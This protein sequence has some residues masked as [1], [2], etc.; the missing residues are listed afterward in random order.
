[1]LTKDNYRI[2]L[3]GENK[4][5]IVDKNSPHIA[6]YGTY[7]GS[8]QNVATSRETQL[9]LLE[10]FKSL[11]NL[12]NTCYMNVVLQCLLHTPLF[13]NYLVSGLY[14]RDLNSKEA[15]VTSLAQLAIVYRKKNDVTSELRNFKTRL[16]KVLPEFLPAM[17]HDSLEFLCSLLDRLKA[18]LTMND[19]V[20][21][22]KEKVNGTPRREED[23]QQGNTGSAMSEANGQLNGVKDEN[24]PSAEKIEKVNE[25]H[26]VIELTE[27]KKTVVSVIDT[28]FSGTIVTA[29]KC[30]VCNYESKRDESFFSL[31]VPIPNVTLIQT[32][33]DYN[34]EVE[35]NKKV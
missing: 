34:K 26:A 5:H 7:T 6:P 1:M 17:Q 24:M 10:E 11:S 29:V 12:G 21:D 35:D 27:E 3:E 18:E 16:G 22:K 32:I 9:K 31:N 8:F 33:G 30:S 28:L 23:G 4:I 2:G 19:K 14:K 13:S 25:A 15:L 20:A